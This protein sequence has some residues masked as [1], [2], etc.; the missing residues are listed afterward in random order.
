[1]KSIVNLGL[2]ILIIIVA[3][4]I[5]FDQNDQNLETNEIPFSTMEEI[6][7]HWLIA[8]ADQQ[9]KKSKSFKV[10]H[11]FKFYDE[12]V[13]SNVSFKHNIVPDCTYDLKPVH[14][15][16]G[17]GVVL[18]DVD[19]DGLYDVYWVSQV[20]KGELWKN[21]GN[22]KFK[23]I[24]S[25]SGLD[26]NEKNIN[27]SA[28]FADIDNDGDADLFVTNIKSGNKLFENDGGGKF[29]D[30]SKSAEID[31]VG[32]SS[33]VTF[34]DFNKDGLLDVFVSNVGKYTTD[35][36]SKFKVGKNEYS[37][38]VG[39]KDAFAGHLKEERL[40]NS[41]LYQNKGNNKF[42]DVTTAM[43]L[44]DQSWTGDATFLDGN[45]DGFPD[46]YLLN[47]Q[48]SD[49]YY[50]N[51][52]GIG[53]VKKSK[54]LFPKTPWG[55]MGIKVFDY[56]NDGLQDIFVSDMH[57]D[58][59]KNVVLPV[60]K[61]KEK[62][63]A[64]FPDDFIV[65][66]SSSIYGNAFFKKTGPN[67]YEE[68]SDAIGAENYWPW[69]ISTGDLNADGFEDVFLASSMNYPYRY[70]MNNVLLNNQG[71]DFLRSEFVLGIEP[72][73][74]GRFARHW[75]SIDCSGE[76]K[77]H[78]LCKNKKGQQDY[79]GAVGSRSSAIFDLDNDGDLDIVTN[80]FNDVPMILIS[81]LT[82]QKTDIKFLKIKLIGTSSNRDG[83]GAVVEVRTGDQVYTKVHDG[84]SGYLSQSSL[85]LYF[86][87]GNA[88][89]VDHIKVNWPS[90]KTQLINQNI[91]IGNLI[92]LTEK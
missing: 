89:S 78:P 28:A 11:D 43:G 53:F 84:K 24:T 63:V 75:F 61:E 72:R 62:G 5:L 88:S 7:P 32:H 42:E 46:L 67:E 37:Y 21:L 1:M 22:G 60:E 87:L 55:A 86:G 40:E 6:E 92:V 85:P 90:G 41:I 51:Q 91:S 23:D 59:G 3:G 47:M 35:E 52:K 73:R 77:N 54:E 57:S 9:I 82:A 30:I 38:F 34:L 12:Q 18:A 58:M 69:G 49:A 64:P 4:F 68:V 26:V 65:T 48:G 31:Y 17:T 36:K 79:Y 83:L 20:G 71:K 76:F 10:F 16:H 74:E 2:F 8:Q 44:R 33:G 70:S 27:V 66:P 45:N 80:E 25:V 50:E 81:N 19:N 14:Y 56:N 13:S 39:Y 29:T 15:D